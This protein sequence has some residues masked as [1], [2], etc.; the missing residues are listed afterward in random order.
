MQRAGAAKNAVRERL[1]RGEAIPGFGH[2][3]YP[4]GDPRSPPLLKLA[5]ERAPKSAPLRTLFSIAEVMEEL[6]QGAPG[7][8]LALVA[9]STALG[10]PPGSATAIFAVARSAGW[11]AHTL[12]QR[13]S[14]VLLRP[15]ARYIGP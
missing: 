3:L 9:L 8:E 7:V 13:R 14:P 1:R 12:E 11:V 10:L 2:P 5:R 4:A 6:G 15:R